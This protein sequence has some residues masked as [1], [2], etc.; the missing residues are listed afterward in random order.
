MQMFQMKFQTHFNNMVDVGT[1][2]QI[3][4]DSVADDRMIVDDRYA[5]HVVPFGTRAS[6]RDPRCGVRRSI[7]R[8][9]PIER[10]RS[11]MP[12]TP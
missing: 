6:T 8:V 12:T 11:R 9:P 7:E 10:A 1:I 3:R 5:D 4:N 2:V